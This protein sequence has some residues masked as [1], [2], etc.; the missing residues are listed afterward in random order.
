VSACYQSVHYKASQ[1]RGHLNTCYQSVLLLSLTRVMIST[2][3]VFW[4]GEVPWVLQDND[5]C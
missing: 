1:M 4:I 3:V 5:G 2:F